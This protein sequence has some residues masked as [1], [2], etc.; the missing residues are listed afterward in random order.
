MEQQF[1]YEIFISC[2]S[3]DYK[4]GRD[5]YDF[6]QKNGITSFLADKELLKL[7]IA[8]YGKAI[9]EALEQS[10]H[11]VVVTSSVSNVEEATSPY[12]Y[13]EWHTFSEEK[14]SGRKDGNI[15]TIVTNKDITKKLPIALRNTESFLYN[16]HERILDYLKKVP[17]GTSSLSNTGSGNV[18]DQTAAQ[19]N[20]SE[21][22]KP[23]SGGHKDWHK[24]LWALLPA[25]ILCAVS[26]SLPILNPN[27][28]Q[29]KN[30]KENQNINQIDESLILFAGGGS[31]ANFLKKDSVDVENFPDSIYSNSIYLNLPSETAW[32]LL[33]EEM[34]RTSNDSIPPFITI[35]VSADSIDSSFI[36]SQKARNLFDNG[37][38]ISY[39]LGEDTLKVYV[40]KN[41]PT[42]SGINPINMNTITTQDLATIINSIKSNPMKA[43]IFTTS[44]DSGTLRA[45]QRNTPKTKIDLNIMLD[46]NQC[47]QFIQSSSSTYIESLYTGPKLPYIILGSC[48]YKANCI[49]ESQYQSLF[50]KD[51]DHF[52]TKPMYVYFVAHT[53]GDKNNCFVYKP[54]IDFLKILNKRI[55]NDYSILDKDKWKVICEKGSITYDSKYII[56]LRK[57]IR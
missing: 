5:L 21:G 34:N 25:L 15:M 45:Y 49:E 14:K 20:T 17:Q 33:A 41:F 16:D 30:P 57:N 10:K 9:D 13:Y 52:V 36:N 7:G 51:G 40:S 28:K 37:R 6:L 23:S 18:S 26:L 27:Y 53:K 12:V 56:E 29:V 44:K 48:F 3:K 38:V 46:R 47:H 24:W 2:N 43:R 54:I 8:D 22:S 19:I 11:L 50:V 55:V 42:I 4:Y 31:A 32:T 35:C 1:E 39:Y